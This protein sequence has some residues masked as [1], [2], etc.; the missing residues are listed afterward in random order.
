MKLIFSSQPRI[1]N[2]LILVIDIYDRKNVLL[3]LLKVEWEIE[4]DEKLKKQVGVS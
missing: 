3:Y 1:Q 4:R 2:Q